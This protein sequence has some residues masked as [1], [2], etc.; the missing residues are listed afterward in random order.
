MAL[1]EN[2]FMVGSVPCPCGKCDLCVKSRK[3]KWKQRIL[4]EEYAHDFSSFITLTYDDKS[5]RFQ[6][7]QTGEFTF[8]TLVPSDLRN[9]LKRI[10]RAVSP[11]KLRF[12]ACG[13]YGDRNWRPHYHLAL[14]G[15]EPCFRGHT[16]KKRHSEGYSCCPPCDLLKD[17]WGLGA[18]DNAP[19][20]EKT[21]SY[22]AG[23]VTKKLT[24][25]SD[26]RLEGRFPEFQRMSNRPGLGAYA[27]GPIAEALFTSFGKNMLTDTGDVPPYLVQGGK[28]L[29]LDRYLRNK[30]RDAIGVNDATIQ[31]TKE[32]FTQELLSM[33]ADILF[34]EEVPASKKP[35]SLK[36]FIQDRDAQKILNIKTLTKIHK[37]SRNL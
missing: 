24:K 26:E 11:R 7:E 20:N 36:Q 12:Y 23:Y 28:K 9:F 5:L 25:A 21:A 3:S 2:P 1:C 14:F 18:V 37:R 32:Q 19:I 31:K 30:I 15:Y 27:V 6:N 4:F 29:Y 17:K 16:D 33:Y 13:E 8:P 10:R 35:H 22:I 34:D